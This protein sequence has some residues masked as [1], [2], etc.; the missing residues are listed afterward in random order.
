MGDFEHWKTSAILFHH[1]QEKADISMAHIITL[2]TKQSNKYVDSM[3]FFILVWTA[4]LNMYINGQ[5]EH[6]SH[7]TEADAFFF[8]CFVLFLDPINFPVP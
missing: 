6:V 4:P 3:Y 2:K 5:A 1:C 8:F 7:N